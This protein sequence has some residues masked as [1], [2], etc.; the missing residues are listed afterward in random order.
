[1]GIQYG[2]MESKKLALIPIENTCL[3]ATI[4]DYHVV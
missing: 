3:P 4:Q 2:K 1:M